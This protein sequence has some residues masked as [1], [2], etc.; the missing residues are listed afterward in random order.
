MTIH[1]VLGILLVSASF[2]ALIAGVRILQNSRGTDPEVLRKL[3][4]VGMGLV[5]LSLPWLFGTPRPVL[6]LAGLFAAGLLAGRCSECWRRVT[7]GVLCGI[8]RPS[9]GDLCF[10]AGVAL[11]FALAAGHMSHFCIPVLTLTFADAAAAVVGTRFGA[12][13]FGG[14]G[15]RKTL[16][17]SAAF[18]LV[19]FLCAYVPLLLRPEGGWAWTFL[20]SISLAVLLTLV[21]AVSGS[22]LDNLTV[23]FAALL[24]LR[25]LSR[26]DAWRLAVCAALATAAVLCLA[27]RAMREIHAFPTPSEIIHE[28]V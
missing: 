17:G 1:P 19:A 24:L 9:V 20:L 10:P 13:Q 11:V 8:T 23:P 21:E 4:H 27:R 15:R 14:P 5:S 16:E 12:H 3:L 7:G 26:V 18:C 28:P 22:G 25:M 2:V 6:L